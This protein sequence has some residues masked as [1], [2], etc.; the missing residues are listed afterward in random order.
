MI[1]FVHKWHFAAILV[2][3]E[4][5]NGL[6]FSARTTCV[7]H[8][9]WSFLKLCG[10]KEKRNIKMFLFS[11]PPQTNYTMPQIK[12]MLVSTPLREQMGR[13]S[14]GSKMVKKKKTMLASAN[15]ILILFDHQT[16][17]DGIKLQQ[18]FNITFKLC[19]KERLQ[20]L[21]FSACFIAFLLRSCINL[22]HWSRTRREMVLYYLWKK[23]WSLQEHA[24]HCNKQPGQIE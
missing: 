24:L 20:Y 21:S 2:L 3:P 8:G 11:F 1:L 15:V 18:K 10:G 4:T 17:N 9:D 7:F 12:S 13:I 5:R 22:T 6:F 19:I 14:R 23:K 16:L